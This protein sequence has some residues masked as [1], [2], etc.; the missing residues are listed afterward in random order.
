MYSCESYIKTYIEHFKGIVERLKG[1]EFDSQDRVLKK[2]ILVSVLDAISRTTSNNADGNRERFTGIIANFGNWPDHTRISAVH[3]SYLL[4]NLRTPAYQKIREFIRETIQNYP[5]NGKN[6]LLAWDPELD[7][8]KTLWPVPLEQKV[9]ASLSLS[10]CTHLS[11]L[12]QYRNNLVHELRESGYGMEAGRGEDEPYYHEMTTIETDGS[13]TE[14][15]ELVYPL[16]FYFNLTERVIH[17][18]EQYLRQNQIN[19]YSCYSFGSSF[20]GSLNID[21]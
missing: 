15:H 12:Y 21:V 10:S 19:P 7:R 17:N 11:L 13:E 16:A 3:V 20:L 14:S 6:I 4:S 9:V 5:H 8:V 2:N 18:V 1:Y